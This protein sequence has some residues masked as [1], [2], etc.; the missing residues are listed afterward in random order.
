MAIKFSRFQ[1]QPAILITVSNQRPLNSSTATLN[2]ISGRRRKARN[3]DN[4]TNKTIGASTF[5]ILDLTRA[6]IAWPS[7]SQPESTTWSDINWDSSV[8]K[9]L[10][11][12]TEELVLRGF[13]KPS[14]K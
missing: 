14:A 10:W 13:I 4:N 1:D 3:S 5:H 6:K 12:A 2:K 7:N 8:A 9:R 11:V